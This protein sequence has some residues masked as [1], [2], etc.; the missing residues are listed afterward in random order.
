MYVC[1]TSVSCKDHRTKFIIVPLEA[2]CLLIPLYVINRVRIGTV[3]PLKLPLL[4]K[5]L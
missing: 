3:F 2:V 5:T 1:M 4:I